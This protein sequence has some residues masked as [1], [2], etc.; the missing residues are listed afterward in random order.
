MDKRYE[1]ASLERY[2]N[3]SNL[4]LISL[5]YGAEGLGIRL[6][7]RFDYLLYSHKKS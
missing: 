7:K 2:D 4:K 1:E 3:D 5:V 6:S